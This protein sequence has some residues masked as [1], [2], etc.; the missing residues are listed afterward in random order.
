M[1]DWSWPIV[2]LVYLWLF[3]ACLLAKSNLCAAWDWFYYNVFTEFLFF[4]V[5]FLIADMIAVFGDFSPFLSVLFCISPRQ[6]FFLEVLCNLI[7]SANF[8]SCMSCVFGFFQLSFQMLLSSGNHL[9]FFN[10]VQCLMAE[11]GIFFCFIHCYV[12]NT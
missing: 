3:P 6:W 11:A 10:S 2:F 12:P 4:S 5:I 9:H 1:D 7:C 8:L